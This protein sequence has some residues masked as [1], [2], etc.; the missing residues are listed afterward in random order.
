VPCGRRRQAR[1]DLRHVV[2]DAGRGEPHVL[3]RVL[4]AWIVNYTATS[5]FQT[6]GR[7]A[8]KISTV[9]GR[10]PRSMAI[11]WSTVQGVY[12]AELQDHWTRS[13]ALGLDC[14]L[15]VFE[16]L[17]FDHH[18]DDDYAAVVRFI[19]WADVQ[20]G[21]RQLSG[22]AL[23]RIA[24]PR[25]YQHAV[26]EARWRTREE[27]VQD[28]RPEIIEH[29]QTAGTWL[30]APILVSDQVIGSERGRAGADRCG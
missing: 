7:A 23:R 1:L 27:G 2:A 30:R 11:R 29:W 17:F 24:V 6:R 13:Y 16:Q 3:D 21:E 28:D 14:P 12:S 10:E 19:E 26:D 25:P 5:I 18:G 22:V 15:D 9:K 4:V 20:W 8:G